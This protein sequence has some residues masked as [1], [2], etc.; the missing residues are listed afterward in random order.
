M[1]NLT[2]EQRH[3][4]MSNIKSKDTSV[5]V[6]LRKALWNEGIRYRKNVKSLPGKPDIAIAKYKLAIF[7]DGELWHGKN[8][9]NRKDTIKTNKDYWIQKIERN[10]NRDNK[11]ERIL[12][13]N[14][15][16]VLRYWGKEIKKNLMACVNEIKET[17]YN[18]KHGLF[19]DEYSTY[20]LFISENDIEY[21]FNEKPISHD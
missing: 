18:I 8:W 13:N 19:K 4:S 6:L 3:K 15:W 10:I 17:I 7:C 11:N 21:I 16:V 1:D 14:G 2:P 9:E 12:E 20:D 5:E